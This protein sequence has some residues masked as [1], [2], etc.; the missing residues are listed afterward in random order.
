LKYIAFGVPNPNYD[1]TTFDFD[2][3]LA[4][5]QAASSWLDAKDSDL[6][7]FKSH[8]GKILMYHGWADPA[9]NP[10]MTVTY[11]DEVRRRFGAAT[12]DFVRLFMVPGMFHC[13]GGVGVDTF[14]P[15]TPL[16]T[17]TEIGTAP[18]SIIGS[19]VV[20]GKTARTRPLCPYPQTAQYKNSGS[21]DEA[22]NFVCRTPPSDEARR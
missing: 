15:V 5:A 13:N 2:K 22:A 20:D 11:F 8:G 9:L 7:R 12:D 18:T 4:R 3:D 10:L 19:H 1:W 21:I 17:W 16:V 14:D 6:T